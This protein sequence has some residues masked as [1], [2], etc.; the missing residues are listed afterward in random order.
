MGNTLVMVFVFKK[1]P[2]KVMD[3]NLLRGTPRALMDAAAEEGAVHHG[4]V[5]NQALTR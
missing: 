3:N 2:G 5:F 1:D 4:T